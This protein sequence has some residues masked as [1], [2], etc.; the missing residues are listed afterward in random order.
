LLLKIDQQAAELVRADRRGVT[1]EQLTRRLVQLRQELQSHFAEEEMGGCL[2]EAVSRRPSLSEISKRIVSEHA[3][4]DGM[5]EHL[6]TQ[7]RDPKANIE[8]L[9]RDYRA[10]PRRFPASVDATHE[11]RPQL[12]A[13]ARIGSRRDAAK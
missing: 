5:L 2:E 8:D 4:L 1:L 13:I 12:V 7:T 6:V 9:Q 11:R 3:I 10:S